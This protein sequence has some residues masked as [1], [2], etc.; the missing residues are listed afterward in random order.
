[1][2]P[3]KGGLRGR[4]S[5]W[6]AGGRKIAGRLDSAG[7]GGKRIERQTGSWHAERVGPNGRMQEANKCKRC[8]EWRGESDF[9][10][11]FFD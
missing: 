1:M 11:I 3:A 10:L 6:S 9:S 4:F 8:A 2:V 7:S 5:L